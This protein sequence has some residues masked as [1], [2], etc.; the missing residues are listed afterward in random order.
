[1]NKLIQEYLDK[2]NAHKWLLFSDP[3]EVEQEN[4]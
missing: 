4:N 3:Y 1:M 2:Q